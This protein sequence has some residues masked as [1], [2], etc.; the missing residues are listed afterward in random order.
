MTGSGPSDIV[1]AEV[2]SYGTTNGAAPGNAI[3]RRPR[4]IKKRMNSAGV[5]LVILLPWL[6]YCA[7]F[8]ARTF[9]FRNTQSSRS[10]IVLCFLALLVCAGLAISQI[11]RQRAGHSGYE[12]MWYV[13]LAATALLASLLGFYSGEYNYKTNMMDYFTYVNLNDYSNVDPALMLGRTMMDAGTVEFTS[14]TFLDVQY[15]TGFSSSG[16]YCVTPINSV[17]TPLA[18]YDFWAVGINCCTGEPNN[19]ACGRNISNTH[20]GLRLLHE[21]A[22]QYYQLAVQK[23]QATYGIWAEHPLFFSWVEDPAKL[24][25]AWYKAGWDTFMLGLLAYL[26]FQC[27]LV[28]IASIFFTS[29]EYAQ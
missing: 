17:Q 11:Q 2:P 25:Q 5:M 9:S 3:K 23:A 1:D 29:K 20:S 16:M 6:V 27:F 7:V 10:I 19:F 13:F 18:S 26:C 21:D 12:P 15:S 22:R 28:A 8:A 24:M 14:S 4:I